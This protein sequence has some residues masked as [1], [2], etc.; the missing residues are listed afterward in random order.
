[1]LRKP[2]W[3]L[4]DEVLD[5]LDKTTLARIYDVLAKDLAQAGVIYIGRDNPEPNPF[6]RVLHLNYA[7]TAADTPSAASSTPATPPPRE[8]M[9]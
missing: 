9:L 2:A 8:K 1:L 3:L 5:A 6:T 4:I 7:T